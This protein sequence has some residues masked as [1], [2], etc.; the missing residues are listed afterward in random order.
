MIDFILLTIVFMILGGLILHSYT[1]MQVAPYML[2][3][4]ICFPLDALVKMY[5]NPHAYAIYY[6]IFTLF[7]IIEFTY[8][9]LMEILPTER[10]IGYIFTK[11]RICDQEGIPPSANTII[12][13]SFLKALSRYLFALPFLTIVLTNK[14]QSIYDLL[15]KT[16]IIQE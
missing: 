11:T 4:I 14:K 13:R 9:L 2:L 6:I 5:H 10:T 15:T 12:I 16:V 7:F 3:N 8:Y 1:N